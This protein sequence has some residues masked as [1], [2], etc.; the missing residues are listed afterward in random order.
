MSSSLVKPQ[1]VDK[2]E[3]ENHSAEEI[4]IELIEDKDVEEVLKMLK[5]FFFKVNFDCWVLRFPRNE[6]IYLF[7]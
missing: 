3:H 7:V 5:E 2:T 4:R 1:D 6:I